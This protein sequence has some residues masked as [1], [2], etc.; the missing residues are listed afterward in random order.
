MSLASVI[1]RTGKRKPRKWHPD[2][3]WRLAEMLENGASDEE[4]ARRLGT[5]SNAVVL[6]RKRYRLK[7]R[8]DATMTA[9]AVARWLGI[10]CAKTITAWIEQGWLRGKRIQGR[11]P[12]HQWHVTDAALIAFLENPEHWHR[13]EPD[14]IPDAALREWAADVRSGVRFLTTREVAERCHVTHPAVNAWIRRG[15]LPAVRRGNW[16][17]RE[18]V[19]DGFVPPNQQPKSGI[20]PRRYT[21]DEDARLVAMRAV[22]A[23]WQQISDELNRTPGSVYTRWARLQKAHA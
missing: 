3:L 18:D 16:L 17:V 19:L 8:T 7:S 13:W 10:P 23:T 22:G 12:Y 21:P 11:G 6:A 5:T 15:I 1:R 14:R 2:R 20:S 4:I 9:R